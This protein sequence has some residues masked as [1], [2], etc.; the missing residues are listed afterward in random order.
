L[1]LDSFGGVDESAQ[2]RFLFDDAG[3]VIDVGNA[4][5]A[6]E[7]LGEVRRASRGVEFAAAAKGLA[8]GDDVDGLLGFGELDHA[9]EYASMRIEE[10]IGWPE[11]FH[12]GVESVII[13]Q[14]RAK[15][16]ALGFE[17]VGQSA[18]ESGSRGHGLGGSPYFRLKDFRAQS[19]SARGMP[20]PLLAA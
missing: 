18:L 6:V 17:I 4:R 3:V 20:N 15:D 11:L 19:F 8:E 10:E 13:D 16:A 5:N 7:E 2:D 12:R 9:L 1:L 14:H